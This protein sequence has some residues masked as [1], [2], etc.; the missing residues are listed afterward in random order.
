MPAS[1]NLTTVQPPV[2][3]IA[4]VAG[5]RWAIAPGIF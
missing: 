4:A 5:I 2:A 1:G 3:V